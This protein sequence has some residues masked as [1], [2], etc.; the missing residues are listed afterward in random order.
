MPKFR[1]VKQFIT[2]SN[3]I[4]QSATKGTTSDG[5]STMATFSTI[6]VSGSFDKQRELELVFVNQMTGSTSNAV[7]S[8]FE[9]T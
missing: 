9:I 8:D 7:F 6:A 1:V 2:G 5:S 3:L 4:I